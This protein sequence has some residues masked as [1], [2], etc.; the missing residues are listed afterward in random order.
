MFTLF[1]FARFNFSHLKDSL[2]TTREKQKLIELL[3]LNNLFYPVYNNRN[4]SNHI[5]MSLNV[6]YQ[7]GACSERMESHFESLKK[8]KEIRQQDSHKVIITEN[9]LKRYQNDTG[10][11]N[12]DE[13]RQF[14][15]DYANKN[16]IYSTIQL[17]L[18]NFNQNIGSHLFHVIIR[19]Q[20]AFQINYKEEIIS[21]LAYLA[22]KQ[23][24]LPDIQDAQEGNILDILEEFS[25]NVDLFKYPEDLNP[26]NIYSQP[27]FQKLYKKTTQ[28]SEKEFE[29]LF[30]KLV[31]FYLKVQLLQQN[32]NNPRLNIVMI[33][34]ITGLY[35]LQVFLKN[36]KGNQV[37]NVIQNFFIAFL[38]YYVTI[39]LPILTSKIQL[40]DNVGPYYFEEVKEDI[41]QY[42][43][44]RQKWETWE[45]IVK[46]GTK[47]D[48]VHTLKLVYVLKQLGQKYRNIN[49]Q[50]KLAAVWKIQFE[51]K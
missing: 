38:C 22:V 8:T 3:E 34:L 14:F 32:E 24:T 2:T 5:S 29:K 47:S 33:H 10:V 23:L 25:N 35:S 39:R 20:Y 40:T 1:S 45:E 13:F 9:N 7:L 11:T 43:I 50:C 31:D 27:A 28:I 16:G 48:D 44:D 51:K 12:Y 21:S 36:Y 49:N 30:E 6:L 17:A 19:L 26:T 41:S 37:K 4:F 15:Q 18:E 46:K 42:I